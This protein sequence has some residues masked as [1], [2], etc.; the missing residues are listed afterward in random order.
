MTTAVAH[1]PRE[2]PRRTDAGTALSIEG[3]RRADDPARGG[4]GRSIVWRG[5]QD[6][7][8]RVAGG[9][10]E[11]EP[12]RRHLIDVA[13][14]HFADHHAEGAAAQRFFHGPQHVALARGG[15]RDQPLGSDP[16][17]VETGPIRRAIFGEREIL[18]D[19]EHVSSRDDRNRPL[20][21]AR[22]CVV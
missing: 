7:A 20:V 21:V 12:S 11:R 18:G 13:W 1:E 10:R 8:E 22:A 5:A 2:E 14:T 17:A 16:D 4:G 19:P 15:N 3:W 9:G 6:E